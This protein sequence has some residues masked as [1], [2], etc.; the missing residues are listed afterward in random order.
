MSNQNFLG[1]CPG[2]FSSYAP[3]NIDVL[4]IDSYCVVSNFSKPRTSAMICCQMSISSLFLSPHARSC[5]SSYWLD[6]STLSPPCTKHGSKLLHPA[7]IWFTMFYQKW[8]PNACFGFPPSKVDCSLKHGT[9]RWN[10]ARK[11]EVQ[12]WQRPNFVLRFF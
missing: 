9:C 3:L 4:I 11:K 5:N 8:W 6:S 2:S 7:G 12:Y 1:F 10:S